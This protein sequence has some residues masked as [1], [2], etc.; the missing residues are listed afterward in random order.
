MTNNQSIIPSSFGLTF[1]VAGDVEV[2]EFIQL[3]ADMNVGM[4]MSDISKRQTLRLVKKYRQNL[5]FGSEF[6]AVTLS[7]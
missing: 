6:P 3:G 1:C 7:I 4:I 2:P 5:K